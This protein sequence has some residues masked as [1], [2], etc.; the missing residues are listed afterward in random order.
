MF[1][2]DGDGTVAPMELAR[3]AELYKDSKKTAKRLMIFSGVL[4]IILVALVAVIVSLTAVVVE[5]TK[6][7]KADNSGA[8]VKKGTSTPVGTAKATKSLALFD[9]PGQTA[10]VLSGVKL[11]NLKQFGT[12]LGYT[13]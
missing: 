10:G 1:D 4:L 2:V 8:L 6:E 7:T 13:R 9:M 3:G 11:I 12:L 5:E